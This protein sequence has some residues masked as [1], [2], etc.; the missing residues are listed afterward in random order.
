MPVSGLTLHKTKSSAEKRLNAAPTETGHVSGTIPPFVN[1]RRRLKKPR[2]YIASNAGLIA[3]VASVL[4]EHW[5]RD[6]P[7]SCSC[8]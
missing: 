6:A 8:K 2:K 7:G 1:V 4:V 5:S 3:S